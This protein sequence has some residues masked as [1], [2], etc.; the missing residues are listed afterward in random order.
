M[1]AAGL[2]LI[3]A[4]AS[5]RLRVA[6]DRLIYRYFFRAREIPFAGI[7]SLDVGPLGSLGGWSTLIVTTDAGPIA[8]KSL[9]GTAGRIKR[10]I[11][12]LEPVIS[13]VPQ[14]A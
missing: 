7:R 6:P 1:L 9:G 12:E 4:Q 2:F 13:A 3:A 11:A 14:P 5:N 10:I 8:I